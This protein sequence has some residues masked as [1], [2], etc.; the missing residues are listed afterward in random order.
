M[1]N[2]ILIP[3]IIILVGALSFFNLPFWMTAVGG[4]LAGF[5][6]FF[7]I[8]AIWL[9]IL[10]VILLFTFGTG[11]LVYLLLWILMPAAVTTAE[12]LE[13]TGEAVNISNI[14][15]KVREEFEN[16]SE[17]FKNVDY[18]KF[19]KQAKTGAEKF[20]NNLSEVIL[21][22]FSIL[23]KVI[24]AF[25]VVTA[26]STLVSLFFFVIKTGANYFNYFSPPFLIINSCDY[27]PDSL[28]CREK[29]KKETETFT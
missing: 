9:R 4:V 19:G 5:G 16:I 23:G 3:A 17:K 27:F 13:M 2:I 22:I 1:K 6:H 18:D 15:K 14:E 24:G 12:K 7:G 8:D 21:R 29:P 25:L 10:M 28:S 11:I 26:A 20:G